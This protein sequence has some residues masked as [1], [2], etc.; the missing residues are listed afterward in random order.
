MDAEARAEAGAKAK[1]G[2]VM[3]AARQAISRKS[4]RNQEAKQNEEKRKA[5]GD[6]KE[7]VATAAKW[8]TQQRTVPSQQRATA[9]EKAKA[10][11]F[12]RREFTEP[13]A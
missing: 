7:C 12:A 11:E 13:V 1:E 5:K 2:V 8:D 6:F 9:K 3:N 4:A 10:K